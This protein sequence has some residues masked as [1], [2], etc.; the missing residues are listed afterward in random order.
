MEGATEEQLLA[1]A[2]ERARRAGQR[3]GGPGVAG[4]QQAVERGAE[5]A[6]G[7]GRSGRRRGTPRTRRCRR[8]R[9]RR[10]AR[11]APTRS[12]RNGIG[13]EAN[14]PIVH[15]A[16][17]SRPRTLNHAEPLGTRSVAAS[18]A[19]P[20]TM[21]TATTRR[22][23][24]R[25]RWGVDSRWRG[26]RDE[27]VRNAHGPRRTPVAPTLAANGL[28]RGLGEHHRGVAQQLIESVVAHHDLVGHR[29]DQRA[30][31]GQVDVGD[32]PQPVRRQARATAAERER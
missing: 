19:A 16:A 22:R 17:T 14:D 11:H 29:V 10:T 30:G 25:R 20:T 5:R 7:G 4:G 28:G 13:P 27:Q 12:G 31:R 8:R 32:D 9:A 23:R 1:D 26:G 24:R 15:V 3:R 2:V 18:S 21:V 6:A